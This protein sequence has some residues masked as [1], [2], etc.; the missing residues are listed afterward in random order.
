[1][2]PVTILFSNILKEQ[3]PGE[4]EKLHNDLAQV[5]RKDKQTSLGRASEPTQFDKKL[6]SC[7]IPV[8]LSLINLLCSVTK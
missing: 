5:T 8:A 7:S 6:V 2:V 4:I 3:E 1:M